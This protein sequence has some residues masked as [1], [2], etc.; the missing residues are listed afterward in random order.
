MQRCLSFVEENAPAKSLHIAIAPTKTMER[1]E[2]FVEKATEIG[3]DYITPIITANSERRTLK[4][5]RLH[6]IMLS[7]MKQS[8]RLYLPVLNEAIAFEQFIQQYPKGLIAHCED[9]LSKKQLYAIECGNNTVLL[10]GPEGDFNAQEIAWALKNDYL[11][12]ALG[13]NRLRTETAGVY[14]SAIIKAKIQ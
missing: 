3:V 9:G 5:E 13:N 2:W 12:V 7:A 8:K 6:K 1:M 10:I 11:A 14:A 4:T